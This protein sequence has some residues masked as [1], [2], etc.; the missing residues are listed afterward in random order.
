VAAVVLVMGLW[1]LAG[2]GSDGP[3]MH[4]VRGRVELAGGNVADLAGATVEAALDGDPTVRASGVL[5]EDGSFTLETL[6]NGVVRKGAREGS[7]K[8]RIFPG[9]D[10]DKQA[11]K[12]VRQALN[13]KYKQFQT[14]D[15]TFQVPT[16][17]EV[18][19]KVS[20]R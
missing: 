6:H 16:N 3:K 2:C 12:R 10:E 15:L 19:L 14:S 11:R 17:G 5:A 20:P 9:D 8:A 1:G 13:E 4:T 7:Y 18:V